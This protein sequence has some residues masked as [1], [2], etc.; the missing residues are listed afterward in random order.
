MFGS[1]ALEA[2]GQQH[3]QPAHTQPFRFAG[4]NELIDDDLGAVGEITELGLPQHQLA[5]VEKS[6]RCG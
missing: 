2:V 4:S 6:C 3:D 5:G 1:L